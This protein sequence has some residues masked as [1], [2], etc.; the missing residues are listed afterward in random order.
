MAKE[1]SDL[2]E[3]EFLMNVANFPLPTI[4]NLPLIEMEL[5][6]PNL[7]KKKCLMKL[8]LLK[9]VYLEAL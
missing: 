4:E 8:F 3:E 9:P 1:K 2:D 5:M 6:N 7:E